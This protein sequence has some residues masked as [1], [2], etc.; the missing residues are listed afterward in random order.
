MSTINPRQPTAGWKG[1]DPMSVKKEIIVCLHEA[2]QAGN[3]LSKTDLRTKLLHNPEPI[4]KLVDECERMQ[5]IN[6]I[7]PPGR[8]RPSIQPQGTN[9]PYKGRPPVRYNL[10]NLGIAFLDFHILIGADAWKGGFHEELL[11][12]TFHI[13]N[14]NIRRKS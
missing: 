2:E 13:L 4:S 3:P 8:G 6:S 1:L 5:V 14:L 9:E 7:E 12:A 11:R 10:T